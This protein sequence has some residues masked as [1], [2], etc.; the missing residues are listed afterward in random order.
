MQFGLGEPPP[1]RRA[2]P[3]AS[4]PPAAQL[5]HARSAPAGP[6]AGATPLARGAIPRPS[7]SIPIVGGQLRGSDHQS[8]GRFGA[9]RT[10]PQGNKHVHEGLDILAAR[11][12]PVVSAVGGVVTRY[13]YASTRSSILRYIEVTTSSGF[14]VR[15]LYVAR[16]PGIAVG[17]RVT[18]G[19]TRIGTVQ[20][21]SHAYGNTPNH[22]HLEI[23]D[24]GVPGRL[25]HWSA[26]GVNLYKRKYRLIDPTPLFV[27]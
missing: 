6:T 16:G 9:S 8:E 7:L 17:T 13:G 5:A 27:P 23:R 1:A 2:A 26:S 3:T 11:G 20:D 24:S 25:N 21:L 4:T 14:V 15:L 12:T 22:V 18:A 10:D 19:K